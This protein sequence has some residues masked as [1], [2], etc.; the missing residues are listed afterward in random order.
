MALNQNLDS[1]SLFQPKMK[2]VID[3]HNLVPSVFL[4]NCIW[5]C[6]KIGYISNDIAIF[7]RDND[8]QNHWVFRGLHNIFRHTHLGPYFISHVSNHKKIVQLQLLGYWYYTD[9]HCSDS[10]IF[11]CIQMVYIYTSMY[12]VHI[13]IYIMQYYT[14]LRILIYIYMYK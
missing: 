14:Y 10:I 9:E 3:L 7:H 8:Q 6:L 4:Y 1:V 11:L 5:V 2:C 12:H 13:Y